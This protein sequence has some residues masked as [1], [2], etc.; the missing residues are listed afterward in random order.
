MPKGALSM[1]DVVA[2]PTEIAM[3]VD[4]HVGEIKS[5]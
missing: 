1:L 4:S 5:G 2:A 3:D